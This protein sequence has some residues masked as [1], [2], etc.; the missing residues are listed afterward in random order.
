MEPPD[1]RPKLN[2]FGPFGRCGCDC[3]TFSRKKTVQRA[4]LFE[5]SAV[6]DRACK[7]ISFAA[8]AKDSLASLRPDTVFGFGG[9]FGRMSICSGRGGDATSSL[10][11]VK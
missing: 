10:V 7:A 9:N 3:L 11:I 1:L 6:P 4:S 2:D 5:A 8:E